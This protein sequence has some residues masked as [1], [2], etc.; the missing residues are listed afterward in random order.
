MINKPKHVLVA[1]LDWGL[2]HA[3]RCIPIIRLLIKKGC[4][5]SIA[6]NGNAKRLLQREFPDLKFYDLPTYGAVYSRYIPFMIYIFLQVPKFLV[7]IV[8][9]RKAVK[10]IV[11]DNAVG[12]TIS[13]N[14]YGCRVSKVPSVFIC[15]QI[16]LIMPSGL[17]WVSPMVNYF[18]RKWISKYEECWIPDDQKISLSGKLSYPSLP[19]AKYVGLL[20]RFSM[21]NNNHTI[22]HLAIIL[23]GPEP[24][25]TIF[26]DLILS[27]LNGMEFKSIV[28][29]G[30]LNGLDERRI[31]GNV[32]FVNHLPGSQLQ[33]VLEES[34]FVLCRSGYS[35]IMDLAVLRKKAILV[36]TPGQTEQEYLGKLMMQ[37]KIA[38]CQRQKNFDLRKALS[39]IKNYTGFE[40][41]PSQPNLLEEVI[42]HNLK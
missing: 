38:P 19:N 16:N 42:D 12:L 33:Q 13:D 25:R 18:N 6:S 2:G 26:E 35:S 11:K 34:E 17:G 24:Q 21:S 27:Q 41:K 7:A 14:R 3:T 40:G 8:K 23:S 30:V 31:K 32:T 39:E 29:R 28:V 36:P 37:K 10:K 5:V 9:E 22:F 15:H 4:Q 1:P 20:S